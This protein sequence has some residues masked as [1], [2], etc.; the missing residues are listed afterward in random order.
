[1][2]GTALGATAASLQSTCLSSV[3]SEITPED[4]AN[5][6]FASLSEATT[7]SLLLARNEPSLLGPLVEVL[8]GLACIDRAMELPACHGAASLA[9]SC[10]PSTELPA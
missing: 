1:M 2:Y 8:V 4:G 6:S 3:H 9:W 7:A 5:A 10:Q